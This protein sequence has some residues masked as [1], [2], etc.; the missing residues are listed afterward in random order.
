MRKLAVVAMVA[1]LVVSL[2]GCSGAGGAQVRDT[3]SG[4]YSA[5]H[6]HDGSGACALLAPATRQEVASSS[7]KPCASGLL[8][9]KIPQPGRILTTSVFGDQ[10]QV[11]LGADTAFV[12]EFPGGWK[13]VAVGC[14]ARPDQ[15]Y[16]CEVA[17]G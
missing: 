12:A 4:F 15:P 11:R 7:G 10:A 17:P 13:V 6:R 5:F 8:G 16:D 9:E 1:V 2:S 3:V 14:T